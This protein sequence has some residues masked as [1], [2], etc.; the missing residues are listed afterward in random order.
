VIR[1]R[2][3][4]SFV[5]LTFGISYLLGIPFNVLV[6]S[7]TTPGTLIGIYAPRA[8]TVIGP[9]AAALLV[10][11]AGGGPVTVGQL[12][13]SLRVRPR[14]AWLIAGWA[15]VALVC[16]F[17]AFVAAGLAAAT[18]FSLLGA[19]V[20]LLLAHVGV[21]VLLI[22]TGEEL[23]WRGW[24]LPTLHARRSFA[25]ATALTAVTWLAWHLPLLLSGV[26]VALS[27]VVMIAALSVSFSWLWRHTSG[28]S[29]T[30]A[31]AHGLV[32][33][34]FFFF[35]GL[36]RTMTDGE[37]LVGEAFLW[38]ATGYAAIA[39]VILATARPRTT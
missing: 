8:V 34:P 13:G 26:T 32:N 9:A 33:A 35:E 29:G 27:F 36:V 12:L 24:L 11:R 39:L 14:D 38:S 6:S 20:P 5:V 1:D 19:Q 7:V 31:I 2:P 17:T 28:S 18:L 15:L 37:A 23:G 4:A 25:A 22:G 30:V 21:Q 16:T 10:A 3:V